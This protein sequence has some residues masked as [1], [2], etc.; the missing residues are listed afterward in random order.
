MIFKFSSQDPSLLFAAILNFT[1]F[2]QEMTHKVTYSQTL[3]G[4]S[5]KNA[6]LPIKPTRKPPES[7]LTA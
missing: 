3:K 7:L 6:A 1:M 2:D 5:R 4:Q